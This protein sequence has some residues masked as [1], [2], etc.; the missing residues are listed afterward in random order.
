MR[1]SILLLFSVLQFSF[2]HCQQKNTAVD[3][4]IETLPVLT[5]ADQQYKDVFKSLDGTWR[6]QFLIY[7]DNKRTK[8]KQEDLKNI[9]KKNLDN[10]HLKQ[11]GN[12]EVTQVYTSESPYF[13]KVVITDFYS[14]KNQKVVSKGINKVENGKMLCIVKKPDETVIHDGY[15]DANDEQTIIWYRT[16][17][18]PQKVE[19][20]RETVLE[21]TYEIIGWGYYEGDDTS[22][23]PRLWFHGKY[24]RQ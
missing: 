1:L 9:S 17:T 6:G 13:Q 14:D 16:E 18:S 19:F 10:K 24:V 5:E 7:E 11:V 8:A 4:D 12:I 22:L 21:K 20:F 2:L 23:S 15:V 3:I